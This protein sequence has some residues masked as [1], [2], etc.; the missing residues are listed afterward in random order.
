MQINL[1]NPDGRFFESEKVF[2]F[3][4]ICRLP[5]ELRRDFAFNIL[6]LAK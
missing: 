1:S 2:V 3:S 4:K 6:K 5:N